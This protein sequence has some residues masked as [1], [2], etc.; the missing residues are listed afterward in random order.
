VT[1]P[2]IFRPYIGSAS[3][4]DGASSTFGLNNSAASNVG[5]R[6]LFS[7][8]INHL[9]DPCPQKNCSVRLYYPDHGKKPSVDEAP[10][11]ASGLLKYANRQAPQP[12]GA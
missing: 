12:R 10:E 8:S 5:R 6:D 9:L 2:S 7:A 1:V 3:P 11:F 4:N